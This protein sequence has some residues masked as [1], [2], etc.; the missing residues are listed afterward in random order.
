MVLL[1]REHVTFVYYINTFISLMI[2]S[3]SYIS[4]RFLM[5][6]VTDTSDTY[7]R[8]IC[9]NIHLLHFLCD[10][11]ITWLR[12]YVYSTIIYLKVNLNIKHANI[13]IAIFELV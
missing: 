12:F 1:S 11:S 13:F 9:I 3:I 6:Q 10:I 5:T 7:E 2:D 8:W 4:L